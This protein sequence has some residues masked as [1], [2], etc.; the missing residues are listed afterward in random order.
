MKV[1]PTRLGD[2]LI[3]E[4]RVFGD[5]RGY[6]LET[7]QRERYV[8]RGMDQDFVQDNLSFSV[9][10]TLR[11]LHFQFRQAQAKLV[12]VLEGEIFDVAVD[13]RRG[14]PT[15]GK[16]VGMTLSAENHH[17]LYIPRG[18]AHGFCVLSET[19][20]FMYKCSDYYLPQEEGG[21][22][23]NDPDLNIDWPVCDP[24]LSDKDR[25]FPRLSQIAA[26]RLPIYRGPHDHSHHR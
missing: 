5:Q 2:V 4:P 19:A 26:D 16:S 3:I 13:I 24:I 20:L 8:A 23:W 6:F 25:R 15:F 14:S 10:N 21:I 9:R 1:T 22:C 18:F 12:Q 7:F 11:G 17:Q